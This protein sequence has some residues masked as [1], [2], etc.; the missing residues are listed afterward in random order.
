MSSAIPKKPRV[1]EILLQ[2]GVIDELQL[3][4]ALGEQAR[5]GSRLG[6]TLIKMGM[7][8]EG[9]LIRALAQQLNLPVASLKGKKLS[10]KVLAL[11]PSRVALEHNVIPLFTSS[12]DR[13]D[14]LYLGM[15]DPSNLDVL[16][17]LSFR[18][19][20]E[21]YPVM[22]GPTDLQLALDRYYR[23]TPSPEALADPV[24]LELDTPFDVD[25]EDPLGETMGEMSLHSVT[26]DPA[27]EAS[28]KEAMPPLVPR[29]P[30]IPITVQAVQA[31]QAVVASE[32][33]PP[34]A[35]ARSIVT[36][37]PDALL[38]T[39]ADA[40]SETERTRIVAKAVTAL[41]IEKGILTLDEV[42]ERTRQLKDAAEDERTSEST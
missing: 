8:E 34:Q 12:G 22:V 18:T 16:D 31:V 32:D 38:D 7:A 11:V 36:T 6:M 2:A 17:D 26:G 3:Q 14:Q 33:L 29:E 5:W 24:P 23:R 39:I 28:M 9:H 10:E 41:L 40:V 1:G 35:P 21:V 13:C 27:D 20:M 4:A 15:E 42:Q 19:G 37:I 30:M 25:R